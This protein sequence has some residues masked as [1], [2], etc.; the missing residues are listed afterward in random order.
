MLCPVRVATAPTHGH[1]FNAVTGRLVIAPT[2]T[3][4]MKVQ[5]TIE[6]KIDLAKTINAVALLVVAIAKLIANL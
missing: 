3:K 4:P 6:V 2:W 5:I 1:V